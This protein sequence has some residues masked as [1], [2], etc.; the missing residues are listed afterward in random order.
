MGRDESRRR[1]DQAGVPFHGSQ[2]CG[3][4]NRRGR[5][6]QLRRYPVRPAVHIAVLREGAVGQLLHIVQIGQHL[7]GRRLIPGRQ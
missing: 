1:L 2:P 3:Q 6:V 7:T 4:Q 5:F